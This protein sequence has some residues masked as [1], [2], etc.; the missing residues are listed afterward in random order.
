MCLVVLM[1]FV[2]GCISME[3]KKIGGCEGGVYRLLGRGLDKRVLV[4]RRKQ[5]IGGLDSW[6]LI[7]K[8]DLRT[9]QSLGN[10]EQRGSSFA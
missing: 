6:D 9:F 1:V 8:L 7:K 2:V 5:E 4:G 3:I 10:D